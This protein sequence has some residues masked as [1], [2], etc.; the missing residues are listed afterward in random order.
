MKTKASILVFENDPARL[1]RLW[2]WIPEERDHQ[3][4]LKHLP[5]ANL[6]VELLSQGWFWSG[7]ALDYDLD[8]PETSIN[9]FD[10]LDVAKVIVREL[11]PTV[12]LLLYSMNA[13]GRGQMAQLLREAGFPVT[14]IPFDELDQPSFLA[15]LAGEPQS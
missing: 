2:G 9:P 14:E 11:P 15:W 12:P 3:V 8:D 13:E 10:G 6:G 4:I 1:H 5:V 7:I